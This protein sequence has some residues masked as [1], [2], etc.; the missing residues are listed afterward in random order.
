MNSKSTATE[1]VE[2][3]K[4]EQ[5]LQQQQQKAQEHV[6]SSI[7]VKDTNTKASDQPTT[8]TK[9]AADTVTTTVSAGSESDTVTTTSD[10]ESSSSA[11]STSST[12]TYSTSAS[13]GEQDDHK[14]HTEEDDIAEV[15]A[16]I[17]KGLSEI[18]NRE[19]IQIEEEVHGVKPMGLSLEEESKPPVRARFLKQ[20]QDM[21]DG[22]LLASGSADAGAIPE[23]IPSVSPS[24]SPLSAYPTAAYEIC[25]RKNY[26]YATNESGELRLM[27]LRAELWDTA[28]ACKRFLKHLAALY[29]YY[30]EDGLKQPL[31]IDQLDY[32]ER[33]R[34]IDSKVLTS[35]KAGRHNSAESR[36][37]YKKGKGGSKRKGS[38]DSLPDM[39]ALRSGSIQV[40]PSR[41]RSG[42]R[43]VVL[44]AGPSVATSQQTRLQVQHSKVRSFDCCIRES[45][46]SVLFETTDDKRNST[47]ILLL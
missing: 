41:D 40:L 24:A 28:K 14:E 35:A 30:G 5:Q 21:I 1:A 20:L 4:E 2:M 16:S 47:H 10:H 37:V 38:L 27:C 34:S 25:L 13:T 33:N 15:R 43:V 36:G 31:T 12:Y 7:K 22:V 44:Q 19:R 6:N 32:E 3:V 42:R 29:K 18:S 39:L 46:G 11:S 9:T 45:K 17:A 8:K 23:K 26:T